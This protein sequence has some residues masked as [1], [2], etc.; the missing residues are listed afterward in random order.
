MSNYKVIEV[1]PDGS[2]QSAERELAEPAAGQ[3][4]IRV[5]ACGVCHSDSFTVQPHDPGQRSPI[6]GHEIVGVIDALGP[7]VEGW[8]TGQR[9][10]V[11]FLGGHCGVCQ[12]CRMGNFVACTNQPQTGVGID[13]GYAEVVYARATGLVAVPDEL[14]SAEAAPLLCAGFTTFNAL[15]KAHTKADDL[16]AIQG[17]GGLG[18][19]GVQYAAKMGQRVVAVARGTGKEK[20]AR[21]LGAHHYIDST[22]TDP[23]EELSKLGGAQAVIATAA[24]GDISPLLNGLASGGRLVVVG[25]SDEPV[26]V[27]PMQLVFGDVRI[28]GSLTGSAIQNENNLRFATDQG[29]RAMIETRPLSEA[30]EAYERMSS[31]DARFRMVLTV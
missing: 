30:T 17:I 1:A 28:M 3:V 29:I 14:T 2:L 18:H 25:A 27:T 24:A 5:E 13:G 22:E 6:P 16:V 19:L 4:R 23:G 21:E 12:S 11:G 7:E 8:S 20:L 9:V 15:L 10:G 26:K 31:G